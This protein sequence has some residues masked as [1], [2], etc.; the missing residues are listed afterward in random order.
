MRKAVLFENFSLNCPYFNRQK[1]D[2][3]GCE[4]PSQEET[5]VFDGKEEGRCFCFSCP[6]GIEAEQE[7]IDNPEYSKNIDWDGLCDD[8][9]VTEGEYLLVECGE[10]ATKDEQRALHA[11]ERYIYRYDK[12]WLDAHGI[13]NFVAIELGI[14]D[15]IRKLQVHSST[16]GSGQCTSDEHEEAKRIAIH[17]LKKQ[18]PK[19]HHH[20][21]INHI[22]DD[23]RESVCPSC[24]GVIVTNSKEYPRYCTWCGQAIEWEESI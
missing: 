8:G 10:D 12:K 13:E 5:D 7:D 21:R 4:H 11:Y 18:M 23:V 24:L 15:A 14:Q 17:A 16:N 22:E 3:Y 6:L 20:T 1:A 9:E 19:K 2:G